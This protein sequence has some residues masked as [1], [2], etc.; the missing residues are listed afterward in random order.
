MQ[1]MNS[2]T[3]TIFGGSG[4]KIVYYQKFI[5]CRGRS[6]KQFNP[7][8]VL[9]CCVLVHRHLLTFEVDKNSPKINIFVDFDSTLQVIFE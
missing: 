9:A 4:C 7:N 1:P 5:R 8:D 2:V 3:E 6:K